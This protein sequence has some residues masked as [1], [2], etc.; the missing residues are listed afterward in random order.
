[1]RSWKIAEEASQVSLDT[2]SN[3][4]ERQGGQV[5]GE[6]VCTDWQVRVR[7]WSYHRHYKYLASIQPGIVVNFQTFPSITTLEPL[8]LLVLPSYMP[9]GIICR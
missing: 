7:L 8:C 4:M 5:Q 9:L 3:A 1:M 6:V 2:E